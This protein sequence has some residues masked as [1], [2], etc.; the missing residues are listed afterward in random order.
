MYTNLVLCLDQR[1][2]AGFYPLTLPDPCHQHGSLLGEVEST[3]E[4][5]ISDTVTITQLSPTDMV[6]IF[7]TMLSQD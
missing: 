4:R 6:T 5:V 2:F 1:D 7:L 3:Q